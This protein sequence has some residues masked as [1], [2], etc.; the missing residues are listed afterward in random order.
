MSDQLDTEIDQVKTRIAMLYQIQDDA[1]GE[2]Q[3]D[4]AAFCASVIGHQTQRLAYLYERKQLF[5]L[6]GKG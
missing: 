3:Y 5:S 4:I 1:S 6:E 2:G